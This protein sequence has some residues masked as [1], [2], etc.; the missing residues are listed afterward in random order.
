MKKS[1]F[2]LICL[3]FNFGDVFAQELKHSVP[4]SKNSFE[5]TEVENHGFYISTTLK[6]YSG[7][8]VII[9]FDKDYNY[10]WQGV[11]PKF[12]YSEYESTH[13]LFTSDG[14]IQF[15]KAQKSKAGRI[16]EINHFNL[17]G[18]LTSIKTPNIDCSHLLNIYSV[19]GIFYFITCNKIIMSDYLID[20]YK[21]REYTLH[22]CNLKT[23]EFK[24]QQISWPGFVA[25][26]KD[27][28][29]PSFWQIVNMTDDKIVYYRLNLKKETSKK[30]ASLTI[31]F[32]EMDHLGTIKKETNQTIDFTSAEMRNFSNLEIH[33]EAYQNIGRIHSYS[34]TGAS[35]ASVE[36]LSWFSLAK[37]FYDKKSK[38]YVVSGLLG[39]ANNST[40]R[41]MTGVFITQLDENYAI[42]SHTE[43][44]TVNSF[45]KDKSF[46]INGYPDSRRFYIRPV[47]ENLFKIY[48]EANYAESHFLT[49]DTKTKK[50]D[51]FQKPIF[52]FE[53]FIQPDEKEELE[54]NKIIASKTGDKSTVQ[55]YLCSK[56][57]VFIVLDKST[58][59]AD[60]YFSPKK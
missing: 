27:D 14:A 22:S 43:I 37:L 10:Q 44:P 51:E 38:Q 19:N 53:S 4:Y 9:K 21:D 41:G 15:R 34:F 26:D 59:K 56:G 42:K 6:E 31:D 16:N 13:W 35:G 54:L 8:T 47:N 17:N 7:S 23:K 55:K 28:Y 40:D 36:A 49:I 60:F 46:R 18:E 33:S 20:P 48:T 57:L 30:Y 58:K 24:S 5:L 50:H 39:G 52:T 1:V 29:V 25:K 12:D 3:L 2:V 45:L 11:S 32:L